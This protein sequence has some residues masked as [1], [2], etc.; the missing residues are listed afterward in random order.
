MPL[1]A[2]QYR[3]DARS[4]DRVHVHLRTEDVRTTEKHGNELAHRPAVI[5]RYT[6]VYPSSG[7][8]YCR[9]DS[10]PIRPN[11]TRCLSV[12]PLPVTDLWILYNI[13]LTGNR[14]QKSP[15]A[16]TG[17]RKRFGRKSNG[18]KPWKKR[19]V[20]DVTRA[21][22]VSVLQVLNMSNVRSADHI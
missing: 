20:W 18:E 21:Y 4:A 13:C 2:E 22:F 17:T 19:P 3:G 11:H 8:D 10:R 16:W 5:Y 6:F 14:A 9:R 15:N 7:S 12:S 1:T